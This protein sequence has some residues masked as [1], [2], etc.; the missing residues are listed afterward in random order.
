MASQGAPHLP[1]LF[2]VRHG[3][4]DW[5]DTRR[6]TG[7]TDIPWNAAGEA[8]ARRLGAVL[9]RETFASVFTSPLVRARRTGELAGFPG[10]LETVADLAE[11]NY[12][13]YEGRT[14]ADIRR[15]R[16]DW[17]LFR[18]GVPAGESLAQVAARADRFVARVRAIQGDVLA[19]SHGHTIPV[20]AAR[21]LGLAPLSGKHFYTSTSSVNVLG[22]EHTRADPV[23]RLWNAVAAPTGNA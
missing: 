12:G 10:R 21:W 6:H 19:F 15:E 22:Y 9:A 16:R 23:I 17:D 2:L 8:A 7:T 3:D 4:T 1:R 5:T 14:T 13:D 20:T 18:D 11:W